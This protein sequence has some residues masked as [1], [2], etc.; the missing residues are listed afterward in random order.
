[1]FAE[2]KMTDTRAKS[3]ALLSGLLLAAT[4]LLLTTGC[5]A[6][7][8][9]DAD[10]STDPFAPSAQDQTPDPIRE[11]HQRGWLWAQRTDAKLVSDCGAI[12]DDDERY[13]CAT[14]INNLP[15]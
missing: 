13:G 14:Y 3:S 10:A 15:H 6:K 5:S 12:T 8:G 4:S 9:A 1:M 11:A 7:H 2:I